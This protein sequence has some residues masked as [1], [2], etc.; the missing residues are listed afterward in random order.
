MS[1]DPEYCLPI[2]EGLIL[3]PTIGSRKHNKHPR[4][5][6]S[7][8]KKLG[9]KLSDFVS[10]RPKKSKSG[11]VGDNI[12]NEKEIK[13]EIPINVDPRKQGR[14]IIDLDLDDCISLA[15]NN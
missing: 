15:P 3:T 6:T 8:Y 10:P 14:A 12:D 4:W 1:D 2:G 13:I 11:K 5:V 7:K 9:T